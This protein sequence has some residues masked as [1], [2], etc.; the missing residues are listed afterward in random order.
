M[1]DNID[2][3]DEVRNRQ[4]DKYISVILNVIIKKN[5]SKNAQL[6]IEASV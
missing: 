4:N 5:H 3:N 1:K 6:N 2:G